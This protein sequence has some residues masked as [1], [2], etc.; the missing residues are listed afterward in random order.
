MTLGRQVTLSEG[1]PAYS[2][3]KRQAPGVKKCQEQKS[4]KSREVPKAET[5]Q[6]QSKAAGVMKCQDPK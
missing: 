4:A 3:A 6:E 1:H 5:C 2:S